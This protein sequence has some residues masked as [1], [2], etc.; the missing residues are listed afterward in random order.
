MKGG[1]PMRQTNL[2]LLAF[3]IVF[4]ACALTARSQ[5]KKDELFTATGTIKG[6]YDRFEEK[7]K[8]DLRGMHLAT[9]SDAYLVLYLH[10]E[11]SG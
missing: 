8:I 10:G 5:E 9:A 1:E 4:I 2:V 3:G 6:D 11:F 7:T